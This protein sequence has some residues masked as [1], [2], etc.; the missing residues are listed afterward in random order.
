MSGILKVG[1][2]ELV[3]DSGGSGSLQWGSG[4][5][6]GTIVQ[7]QF[8]QVTTKSTQSYSADTDTPIT[9]LQV[10][11]TPHFNN[12]IIKLECYFMLEYDGSNETFTF[13]FIEDII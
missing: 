5:P 1:G 4:V 8:T 12:S 3:N 2:S 10:N 11:I 6:S 9:V 7:T 13:E